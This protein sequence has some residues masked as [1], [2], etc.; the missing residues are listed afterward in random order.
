MSAPENQLTLGR[1]Q[2]LIGCGL[3]VA[4]RGPQAI[5]EAFNFHWNYSYHER[6]LYCLN[7]IFF[8]FFFLEIERITIN[9][10]AGTRGKSRMG[11]CMRWWPSHHLLSHSLSDPLLKGLKPNVGQKSET[12]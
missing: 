11:R 2:D 8:F 4:E 10:D 6:I 9:A 5:C 7:A 1:A 3:G 12:T